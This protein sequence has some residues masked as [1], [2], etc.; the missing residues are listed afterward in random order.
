MTLMF[1]SGVILKGEH[2]AIKSFKKNK[3]NKEIKAIK[4]IK[5]SEEKIYCKPDLRPQK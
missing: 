5:Q 2:S 4:T 3:R 1:D